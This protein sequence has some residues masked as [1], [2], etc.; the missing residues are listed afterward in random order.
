MGL[1]SPD[2]V[3]LHPP[4]VYDFRK[5]TIMFGPI[6]DVIPSSSVFEMYPLGLTSIAAYLENNGFN[7]QIVNVAGKMLAGP[8]YDAEKDIARLNPAIFGVDLHWLPHAHGSIELA[9]LAKKHH[10][11]TPVIFGGLSSSY[12]H[13]ELVGYPWVDMVMRGDSTEEPFLRLM[14]ALRSGG[15]LEEIPNLT[16]KRPDGTVV[17]NELSHVPDSLDDLPMPD[18]LYPIRS[19][20]KYGS[21]ANVVP[22]VG[23]LDYPMTCLILS[24]G[25][26]QNCAVCGGSRFSY[27]LLCNRNSPAYLSPEGLVKRIL[28]IQELSKTPI[29]LVHDLR[30]G[31]GDYFERFVELASRERIENELIIEL[32]FP[33]YDDYFSRLARAVPRFSLEM[34]L[35]THVEEIRRFNGKFSCTNEQVERTIASALQ[36]GVNKID[37]FFMVGIPR[38][39]YQQAV[40]ST[41][42]CRHL[43]EK[44][45]GDRRLWFF[46]APLAPFLDPGCLAFEYPEKYG[47]KKLLHTFEEHRRALLAPSW[48]HILS[49]ET[50]GMTRAEIVEAT[51]EAAS[52]LNKLKHEYGVIGEQTYRQIDYKI[53]AARKVIAEIDEIMEL[54]EGPEREQKL[55]AMRVRVEELN[56][57]SICGEDELKWPIGQRF[58]AIPGLAKVLFGLFLGT[59]GDLLRRRRPGNGRT[60]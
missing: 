6:G 46:I 25:C 40:E 28:Q 18:Y 2:L 17:V 1:F 57:Y 9:K 37:I 3:L 45:D 56:N 22:Y 10:P 60:A 38:Q 11:G 53:A 13:E 42:Y 23:W 30:Q 52:R 7:V 35:E 8:S 32:F 39:T 36:H 31:G 50:D 19:V 21:L 4:S 24:R 16:W 59:A 29:F 43:L 55:Q 33:A 27:R 14:E 48:K 51:Y 12:Y 54:P 15:P 58:G 26:L 49:Y 20:L 44:F 5:S 47:Y 41:D 34:T